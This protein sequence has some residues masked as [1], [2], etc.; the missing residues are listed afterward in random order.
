[1]TALECCGE[2][3][4]TDS[5]LDGV[6][7]AAAFFTLVDEGVPVLE[8]GRGI[9]LDNIEDP[10]VRAVAEHWIASYREEPVVIN[11]D[12]VR[13]SMLAEDLERVHGRTVQPENWEH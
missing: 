4:L 10:D 7:C 6:S 13:P 11:P 3:M 12:R 2:Q 9:S 1:M 8:Y 5:G